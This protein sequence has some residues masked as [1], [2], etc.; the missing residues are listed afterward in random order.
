MASYKI[1]GESKAKVRSFSS[2]IIFSF[3]LNIATPAVAL[4]TAPLLARVF[5]VEG[6]GMVQAAVA[7]SLLI[8]AV[9]ALGVPD[10]IIYVVAGAGDYCDGTIG[11]GGHRGAGRFPPAPDRG[12]V[13]DGERGPIEARVNGEE[14]IAGHRVEAPV[15]A[16]GEVADQFAGDF[17]S[18]GF[19]GGDIV[20]DDRCAGLAGVVVRW[21]GVGAVVDPPSC[22]AKFAIGDN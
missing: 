15:G 22:L 21:C 5:G 7:P 11:Q 17:D 1:K 16:E 18:L 13:N 6:R 4:V 3:I 20:A 9:G 8:I 2:N 10:A 19:S 12:A 14:D